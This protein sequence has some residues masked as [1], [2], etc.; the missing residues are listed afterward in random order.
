MLEGCKILALSLG[1]RN[2]D[3]EGPS[4]TE[5]EALTMFCSNLPTSNRD[6]S[7]S[8]PSQ[9]QPSVQTLSGVSHAKV[10]VSLCKSVI[11]QPCT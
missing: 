2:L 9:V 1:T 7:Q 4:Q 11:D 8:L 6:R 10:R 3:A 5:Q